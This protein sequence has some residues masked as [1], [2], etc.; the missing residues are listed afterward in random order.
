MSDGILRPNTVRF[1][2][3]EFSM[4]GYSRINFPILDPWVRAFANTADHP[5]I[6]QFDPP[7]IQQLASRQRT[8]RTRRRVNRIS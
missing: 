6:H 7:P 8:R 2:L 1:S 5:I 3:T 4:A